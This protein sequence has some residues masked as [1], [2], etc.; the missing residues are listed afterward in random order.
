M[1]LNSR[2]MA[3]PFLEAFKKLSPE[4]QSIQSGLELGFLIEKSNLLDLLDDKLSAEFFLKDEAYGNLLGYLSLIAI[5]YS[6]DQRL[7]NVLSKLSP[8]KRQPFYYQNGIYQKL[9]SEFANQRNLLKY[10]E[11]TKSFSERVPETKN[12][13]Q[14]LSSLQEKLNAL[15]IVPTPNELLELAFFMIKLNA[16]GQFEMAGKEK[17]F[18]LANLIFSSPGDFENYYARAAADPGGAYK[19]IQPIYL[20]LRKNQEPFSTLMADESRLFSLRPNG[21]QFTVSGLTYVK[22]DKR[23]YIK[24][25]NIPL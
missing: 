24:N 7:I 1:A 5:N 19:K 13:I 20:A 14:K 25:I 10:Y 11:S 18:E 4:N 12:K 22:K 21:Y 9:L 15:G 8:D 3:A 16:K 6:S 2:E 17:L 23:L